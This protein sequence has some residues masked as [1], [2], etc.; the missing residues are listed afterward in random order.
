MTSE[1]IRAMAFPFLQAVLFKARVGSRLR[2]RLLGC[3]NLVAVTRVT[4]KLRTAFQL[5]RVAVITL[6]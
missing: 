1:L 6:A 3:V 5:N 4:V 2:L